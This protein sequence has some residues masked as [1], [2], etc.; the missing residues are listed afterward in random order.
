MCRVMH[1]FIISRFVYPSPQSRSGYPSA[2]TTTRSLLSPSLI[3]GNHQSVFHL[4]IFVTLRMLHK[5]NLIIC[6][7]LRLAYLHSVQCPWEPSQLFVV[8]ITI[9]N[10][11]FWLSSNPWYGYT[12]VCLTF[13]YWRTLLFFFTVFDYF[14]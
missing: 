6:D 2:A 14:K 13:T 10:W 5:Q 4:Y 8:Y 7:L 9:L 12:T 11:F 1:H 3:S